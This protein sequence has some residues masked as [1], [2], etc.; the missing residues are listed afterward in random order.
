MA[1]HSLVKYFSDDGNTYQLIVPNYYL[2]NNSTGVWNHGD[3]PGANPYIPRGMKMR[4]FH[5]LEHSGTRRRQFPL[6]DTTVGWPL[7]SFQLV[8]PNI[9]GTSTTWDIVGYSGER[10]QPLT[11]RKRH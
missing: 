1:E 6:D 5:L 11:N 10:D 3:T 4:R 8:L 2:N 9:D 7:P